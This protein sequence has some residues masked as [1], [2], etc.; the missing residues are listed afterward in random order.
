MMTAAKAFKDCAHSADPTLSS[1]VPGVGSSSHTTTFKQQSQLQCQ[2][3][4]TG[5]ANPHQKTPQ[6]TTE[7]LLD[8]PLLSPQHQTSWDDDSE[9]LQADTVSD[10]AFQH[11][12]NFPCREEHQ[13]FSPKGGWHTDQYQAAA[14][15]T[16]GWGDSIP[17]D[18][19]QQQQM[20]KRRHQL[21]LHSLRSFDGSHEGH[22][23][24]QDEM[25]PKASLIT[26]GGH[27]DRYQGSAAIVHRS[28]NARSVQDTHHSFTCN[29]SSAS[30]LYALPKKA[31]Q[32]YQSK[33][34]QS[35]SV[36]PHALSDSKDG[37]FSDT[38]GTLPVRPSRSSKQS[39]KPSKR[40]DE[41]H[42]VEPPLLTPRSQ[43]FQFGLQ[44]SS[45]MNSQS[46]PATPPTL[47][48]GFG[49]VPS[50]LATN[51]LG[52]YSHSPHHCC[53]PSSSQRDSPHSSNAHPDS[54]MH[55][56]PCKIPEYAFGLRHSQ[57]SGEDN[58]DLDNCPDAADWPRD[59][60]RPAMHTGT[61][62]LACSTVHVLL[63]ALSV[64]CSLS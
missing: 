25:H 26:G 33:A 30:S 3:T 27:R 55:S 38:F 8:Q 24:S 10:S 20:H 44:H 13:D 53:Q 49:L 35:S 32:H 11:G 52:S 19:Q 42:A 47:P 16:D 18:Q 48:G 12:R 63:L 17:Q 54:S 7:C 15:E 22:S 31:G 64:C 5:S 60:Q 46:R 43:G 57:H 29:D 4:K 39:Q 37:A 36:S 41:P 59:V 28:N 14:S 62:L 61:W 40:H 45:N 50:Y 56:I 34:T 23:S 21:Q 6:P 9:S 1:N 58:E 2:E 51:P